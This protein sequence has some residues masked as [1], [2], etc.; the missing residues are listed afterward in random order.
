VRFVKDS[1]RE[2]DTSVTAYVRGLIEA[3]RTTYGLPLQVVSTL[4]KDAAA[5]GETWPEYMSHVLFQRYEMVVKHGVAFDAQAEPRDG[6]KARRTGA[7]R[8][9]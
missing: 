1:A 5:L 9:A 7:G 8:A 2:D 6:R 3:V 4:R